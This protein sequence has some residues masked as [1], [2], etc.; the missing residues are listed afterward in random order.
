VNV[1]DGLFTTKCLL[2]S[3]GVA[4]RHSVS[5]MGTSQ[6]GRGQWSAL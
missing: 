6:G 4:G 3:L 1:N 5:A 2:T